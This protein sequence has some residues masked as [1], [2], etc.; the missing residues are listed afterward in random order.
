[1]IKK[2]SRAK[3]NKVRHFACD[4]DIIF[5]LPR[6]RKL[7]A[8]LCRQCLLTPL[9]PYKEPNK[10]VFLFK[11]ALLKSIVFN[12]RQFY[13]MKVPSEVIFSFQMKKRKV[14]E[15]LCWINHEL[16][17]RRARRAVHSSSTLQRLPPDSVNKTR[18]CFSFTFRAH[19][20]PLC[21]INGVVKSKK[22]TSLL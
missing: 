9:P 16:I 17:N 19:Q 8:I 21:G 2:W 7:P 3:G 6:R 14:N 10:H 15:H 22:P 18:T 4:D 20:G 13:A 5:F 1:M 11:A 12:Q